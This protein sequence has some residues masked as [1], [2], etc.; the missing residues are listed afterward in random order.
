MFYLYKFSEHSQYVDEQPGLTAPW[1]VYDFSHVHYSSGDQ[2]IPVP[3][4]NYT[5]TLD[6]RPTNDISNIKLYDTYVDHGSI[7]VNNITYNET[8]TVNYS[9]QIIKGQKFTMPEAYLMGDDHWYHSYKDYFN[10]NRWKILGWISDEYKNSDNIQ[11]I[12]SN[13]IKPNQQITVNANKTYIAIWG[14]EYTIII[15]DV[16]YKVVVEITNNRTTQPRIMLSSTG[17]YINITIA[18]NSESITIPD[19][20]LYDDLNG[21]GGMFRCLCYY[22]DLKLLN[23]Y[24]NNSSNY[25]I[26]YNNW[27]NGYFVSYSGSGYHDTLN[28]IKDLPLY[29]LDCAG[30]DED[31]P[32]KHP[33]YLYSSNFT[34]YDFKPTGIM[35]KIG[36]YAASGFANGYNYWS[37]SIDISFVNHNQDVYFQKTIYAN[38]NQQSNPTGTLHEAG[39][40]GNPVQETFGGIFGEITRYGNI[41]DIFLKITHISLN[42]Y[43]QSN[44]SGTAISWDSNNTNDYKITLPGMITFNE[45]QYIRNEFSKHLVIRF[46]NYQWENGHQALYI[47]VSI[48]YDYDS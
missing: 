27:V 13:L 29:S 45:A 26:N 33:F 36:Y 38:F 42:A 39:W 43:M 24:G 9:V 1:V 30:Y 20:Y 48:F 10:E 28:I 15:G 4:T 21:E 47:P 31:I 8:D 16:T 41:G 6:F 2:T 14:R 5:I 34:Q 23:Y 44:Y 19:C 35:N 11:T 12:I 25:F 3:I 18:S 32:Y 40:Y 17:Q 37:I 7:D 22:C 46:G